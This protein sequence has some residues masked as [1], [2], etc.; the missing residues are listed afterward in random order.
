MSKLSYS[1]NDGICFLLQTNSTQNIYLT[2]CG[3]KR[4]CGKVP[5]RTEPAQRLSELAKELIEEI[6]RIKKEQ[7]KVSDEENVV[8]VCF[9]NNHPF[10]D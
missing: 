1:D 6:K 5:P 9:Y 2:F 7:R 8:D 10:G 3:K 4:L